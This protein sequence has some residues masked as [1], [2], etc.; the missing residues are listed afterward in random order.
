[1]ASGLVSRKSNLFEFLLNVSMLPTEWK[2]EAV[3]RTMKKPKNRETSTG[4]R[5]LGSFCPTTDRYASISAVCIFATY[6]SH[7]CNWC[8][9]AGMKRQRA[10]S[11]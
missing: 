1:M 6:S 4:L 2:K 10:K 3:Q 11:T 9:H 8:S 7:S 5:P